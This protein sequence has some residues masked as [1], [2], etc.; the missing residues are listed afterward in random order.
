MSALLPA[1]DATMAAAGV[2]LTARLVLLVLTAGWDVLSRRL[3]PLPERPPD[4]LDWPEVAVLV[5]AYNE[6]RVI[7]AT[8][9]SILASDYPRLR[10][11]VIDDGSTDDT[12]HVVS[13]LAQGDSRVLGVP[14][15][16]NQG[17]A[18]ALNA[19]LAACDD[20]QLVVTVDA[21]TLL[22]PG[23][24]KLLVAPLLHDPQVASVASNLKVGN[25]NTW[26]T[27]FQSLEYVVGI[28]L[29]RR[30]QATLG[31]ITTVPGAAGAFRRQALLEVGGYSPQTRTEDTD[32]SLDLL[33]QGWRILFQPLALSFTEAP[34]TWRGLMHQRTRWMYGYLQNILKHRR[35][36]LRLD[37]LGWFGMPNLVFLHF[38]VFP[39]FLVSLPYMVRVTEW[40]TAQGLVGFALGL[41]GLDICLATAAY[42]VD[43]EDPRDLILA[44]FQ[45]VFWP[46]FLLAVFFR[47][48]ALVLGR[49]VVGW[50]KLVREGDLAREGPKVVR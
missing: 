9:R 27:R 33:R 13:G 11:V 40:T 45:R 10:V 25:R 48:W 20:L 14:Q 7:E 16:P 38:L 6:A 36:F 43:R 44:P 50:H 41:W 30:A 1:L 21:D 46:F 47:V 26:L 39:L 29:G 37:S 18:E 17:K 35:A 28:N 49:R 31:C 32:L 8:V 15:R 2:A 4:G 34:S 24:I 3:R 23:A 19:G 5:P 22:D 42:L 12:W